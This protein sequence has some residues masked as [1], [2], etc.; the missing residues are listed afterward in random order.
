MDMLKRAYILATKAILNLSSRWHGLMLGVTLLAGPLF[1]SFCGVF[2]ALIGWLGKKPV[3]FKLS[4]LILITFCLVTVLKH[5]FRKTRPDTDY[6]RRM[7]F[8]KYSFPSGHATVGSVLWYG[9][10]LV[11]SNLGMPAGLVLAMTLVAPLV[12]FLIGISRVYLG[13]HYLIDV[14]VGW[15]IGLTMT[16]LFTFLM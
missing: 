5:L 13:A 3:V 10:V 9:I 14:L 11:L 12:V 8:S 7:K 16:M 15:A 1:V 4:L 2:F 6:A